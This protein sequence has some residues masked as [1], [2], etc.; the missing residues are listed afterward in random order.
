MYRIGFGHDPEL[1]ERGNLIA[2]LKRKGICTHQARKIE[3]TQP[4]GIS[5]IPTADA[6]ATCADCG[7]KGSMDELDQ[8]LQ[9]YI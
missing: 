7:A 5:G 8:V 4:T 1:P 9:K 2:E 6:D 3:S